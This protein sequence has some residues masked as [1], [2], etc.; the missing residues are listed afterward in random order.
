MNADPNFWPAFLLLGVPLIVLTGGPFGWRFLVI[1]GALVGLAYAPLISLAVIVLYLLR[2][3][4]RWAAEGLI[5]GFAGGIGARL[6]GVFASPERAER[7]RERWLAR[8]DR[9]RS[10][11]RGAPRARGRRPREYFPFDDGIDRLGD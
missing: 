5:V 10:R 11:E 7:Q 9:R 6:S 8:R 3:P 2:T 4:L 1:L